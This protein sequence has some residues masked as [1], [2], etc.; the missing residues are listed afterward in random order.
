MTPPYPSLPNDP[1]RGELVGTHMFWYLLRGDPIQ[2]ARH[3]LVALIGLLGLARVRL[4]RNF[5]GSGRCCGGVECLK[6][7][8]CEPSQ[9]CLASTAVVGL[10]DPGDDGQA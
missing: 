8:G 4:T 3:H 10:L 1:N 6:F 9:A 5:G 7:D 2:A